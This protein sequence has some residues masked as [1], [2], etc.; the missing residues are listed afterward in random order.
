[1]PYPCLPTPFPILRLKG[2]FSRRFLES[3]KRTETGFFG[4]YDHLRVHSTWVDPA[5]A[6]CSGFCAPPLLLTPRAPAP[7][8]SLR[9]HPN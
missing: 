3:S 6:Y 1:M 4:E 8:R 7:A 5:F 2:G 9:V